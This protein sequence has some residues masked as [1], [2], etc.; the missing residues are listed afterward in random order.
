MD[1][2][3]TGRSQRL[4]CL[5]CF[6]L[7]AV[8]IIALFSWKERYWYDTVYAYAFGLLFPDLKDG[9]EHC[10]KRASGWGIACVGLTAFV[11][12]LTK[13]SFPHGIDAILENVRAICFMTLILVLLSR[14]Q[15]GNSVL[16]W[17]GK[18]VFLCYLLQRLPM[19]LLHHIGVSTTCIPL[20]VVGSVVGTVLLVLLFGPV[21]RSVDSFFFIQPDKH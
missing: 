2:L 9:F 20:F 11:V 18:N 19:I 5:F 6:L 3:S 13:L 16:A 17:L 7:T 15:I 14:F 4:A 10:I 21:L 1:K 8:Y 12:V